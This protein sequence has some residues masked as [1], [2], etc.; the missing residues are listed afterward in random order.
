MWG[1]AGTDGFAQAGKRRLRSGG[2][3]LLH[4]NI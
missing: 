4:V 1:K 3:S 2:V